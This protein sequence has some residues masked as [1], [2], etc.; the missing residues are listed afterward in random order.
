MAPSEFPAAG[1]GGQDYHFSL[2]SWL[3]EDQREAAEPEP[4]EQAENL[5]ASRTS[6]V[7][8]EE[9]GMFRE[10]LLHLDSAYE[11]TLSKGL[12]PR[13][14]IAEMIDRMSI[15]ER[16]FRELTHGNWGIADY[17]RREMAILEYAGSIFL[18][19]GGIS[20]GAFKEEIETALS[21]S[22]VRRDIPLSPNLPQKIERHRTDILRAAANP[23]V[24]KRIESC[25]AFV[26]DVCERAKE[27][28]LYEPPLLE[29]SLQQARALYRM[30]VE[31]DAFS[32]ETLTAIEGR[33]TSLY[34]ERQDLLANEILHRATRLTAYD[35]TNPLTPI[36]EKSIVL[37]L[38][39]PDF[40]C[41]QKQALGAA[42]YE[43]RDMWSGV[44]LRHFLRYTETKRKVIRDALMTKNIQARRRLL[45]ELRKSLREYERNNKTFGT[46]Y[47]N[48]FGGNTDDFYLCLLR[49][50][51]INAM[52]AELC[53]S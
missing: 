5:V 8:Q 4:S 12:S 49:V 43:K 3:R 53:N 20:D 50:K 1:N 37:V 22:E 44:A 38:E 27:K 40:C 18:R 19:E 10:L 29:S 47:Q 6:E 33:V 48:V 2:P 28:M 42:V 32:R 23:G 36:M 41:L 45:E 46:I 25:T 34:F 17:L 31:R 14:A 11:R 39:S 16:M 13:E 9:E 24:Q 7:T 51:M 21:R 15:E 26:M 35:F 30:T 52:E